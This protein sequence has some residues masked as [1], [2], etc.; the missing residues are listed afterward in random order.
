LTCRNG[1][2]RSRPVPLRSGGSLGVCDHSV[3]SRRGACYGIDCL[4]C[5]AV[6]ARPTR[7][8]SSR[9]RSPSW[10]HGGDWASGGDR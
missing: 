6:P 7:S 3:I 4:C 1:T 5:A 8:A 9:A 10:S 2:S